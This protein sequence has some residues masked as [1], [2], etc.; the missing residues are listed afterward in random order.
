VDSVGGPAFTASSALGVVEVSQHDRGPVLRRARTTALQADRGDQ[1]GHGAPLRL[2]ARVPT[3]RRRSSRSDPSTS[4]RPAPAL[5]DVRRGTGTSF[6]PR[7]PRCRPTLQ[8]ARWALLKDLANHTDAQTA[9]LRR[10]WAADGEVW[11]G[12][13]LKEA[14]RATFAPGLSV[15]DVERLVDRF[16]SRAPQ[17]A[18]GVRQAR[19]HHHQASPRD[20]RGSEARS[21]QRSRRGLNN[22]VRLIARR[23][24]GVHFTPPRS[25]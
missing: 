13:T 3:P 4:P 6:G 10:L 24:Y 25:P 12:Y 23:A 18:G 14:L 8:G 16:V 2:K 19:R 22:K 7:R 21:H 20:P 17:P 1:P 15:D 5:D 11:R 9:A